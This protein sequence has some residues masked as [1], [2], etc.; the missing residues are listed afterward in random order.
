MS[1]IDFGDKVRHKTNQDYNA[2][3]ITVKDT[4]GDKALCEYTDIK[5]RTLKEKWFDK[6]DLELVQKAE[7]GFTN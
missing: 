1:N 2:L 6:E 4:E 3:L 7:G 5:D